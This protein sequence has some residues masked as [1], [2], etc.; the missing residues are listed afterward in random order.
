MVN[1][2]GFVGFR[3]VKNDFN[4]ED[5]R[6]H[7]NDHGFKRSSND[8][9]VIFPV[10]NNKINKDAPAPRRS[11]ASCATSSPYYPCNSAMYPGLALVGVDH[12]TP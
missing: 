4:D 1:V 11:S 12:Q 10:T 8:L 6:W 9:Q 7:L 5:H 3:V 2:K